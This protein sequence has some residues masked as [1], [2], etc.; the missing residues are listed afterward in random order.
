MTKSG[1]QYTT[2]RQNRD[3][4]KTEKTNK[5]KERTEKSKEK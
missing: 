5:R 2:Q 1:L 4:D 3:K